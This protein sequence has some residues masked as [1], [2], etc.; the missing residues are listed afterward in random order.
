MTKKT[1]VLQKL[2]PRKNIEVEYRKS[3]YRVLASII[4]KVKQRIPK[5]LKRLQP[6]FTQ[7]SRDAWPDIIEKEL[8]K[9]KDTWRNKDENIVRL[10]KVFVDKV[11]KSN[12]ED[13]ERVFKRYN[14][15]IN[16]FA[17]NKLLKNIV[18][19]RINEN[20]ELVKT[21]GETLLSKV[22]TN[23]YEGATKGLRASEIA[24]SMIKYSNISLKRANF[25]AR[26]QLGTFYS[27]VNK[28]RMLA[29]GVKRYQWLDM[30]DSK[31]RGNPSGKYPNSKRNHWA[32]NGK[33]FEY[34]NPPAGGH[35]GEDDGCRCVAR[36]IFEEE[37]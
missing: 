34:E 31:V 36:P 21:I 12:G 6:K 29:L 17:D 28:E 20:V 11:M 4:L 14:I 1:R 15:G 33:T 7:D 10:S 2:A 26:N 13:I 24:K 22:S 9:I 37:I 18:R 23:V 16:I 8:Q 25:V 27:N 19:A 35:P 5:I 30:R 3:I 32:R